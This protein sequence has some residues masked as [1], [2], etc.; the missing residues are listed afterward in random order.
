MKTT[1]VHIIATCAIGAFAAPQSSQSCSEQMPDCYNGIKNNIFQGNEDRVAAF[2]E[3]YSTDVNF[4]QK[5]KD[6]VYKGCAVIATDLSQ[7]AG[8]GDRTT[9]GLK[10]EKVTAACQCVKGGD[11]AACD[12]DKCFGAVRGLLGGKADL[13]SAFCTVNEQP[14]EE[15]PRDEQPRAGKPLEYALA[16]YCSVADEQG[17]STKVDFDGMAKM[18]DCVKKNKGL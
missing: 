17:W 3:L 9:M 6:A 5:P 13:M 16:P 12:Q 1:A 4:S 14:W 15:Q 10:R 11:G 8:S 18:C 7:S 2:C